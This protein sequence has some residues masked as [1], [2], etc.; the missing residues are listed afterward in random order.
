MATGFYEEMLQEVRR[1][2]DQGQQE[3]AA[4]RI[5]A[6]LA[7]PYVP[8]SVSQQLMDLQR[9]L[10]RNQADRDRPQVQLSLD[11]IEEGLKQ[12]RQHQ[13]QAVDA[14]HQMNL[15]PHLEM[16][17][18]YLVRQP[19]PLASALLIDSLIE[20]QIGE[21]LTLNRDGLSCTFIPRYQEGA[22]ESDGFV[23]ASAQLHD[24][25]ENE[26]PSFLH[27]CEQIL[28]REAYLCLPLGFER[29]EGVLLAASCVRLVYLSLQDE[30]GWRQFCL[31]HQWNEAEFM[32]LKSQFI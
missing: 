1:L 12:D 6:E 26:D 14:L 3:A 28:I 31:Q 15:R 5:T 4:A 27:L 20:Q 2:M 22:A 9:Q 29:E 19:D 7:M 30:A 32:E 24:W 18:D 13:L 11:Q 25:F 16:I 8:P 17:R 23:Q 10:H 21:E